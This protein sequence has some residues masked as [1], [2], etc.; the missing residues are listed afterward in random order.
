MEVSRH[1]SWSSQNEEARCIED[2]GSMG[3]GKHLNI[4]EGDRVV[5]V[6]GRDK[7]KIGQVQKIDKQRAEV[8]CEGLNLIDVAIP[9]WMLG[10]AD[11]D[12]RPTRS[13]PQ[14][15]SLKSVK[16]VFPYTDPQPVSPAT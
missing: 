13:I 7:G 5:V 1:N 10:E 14:G 6:E 4:R 3:R 2:T 15:I 11:Q 8:T 9:E 16:L 12:S